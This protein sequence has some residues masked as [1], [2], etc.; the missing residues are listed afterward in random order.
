[1]DFF[2]LINSFLRRFSDYIC[3]NSNL[4]LSHK[5]DMHTK[6]NKIDNWDNLYKCWIKNSPKNDFSPVEGFLVKA[7]P[8][9]Q[10]LP[11]L[12]KTIA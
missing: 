12:P 1:M 10:S 7:T 6:L 9:E 8:V 3:L 11:I 4:Y 5:R 2:K